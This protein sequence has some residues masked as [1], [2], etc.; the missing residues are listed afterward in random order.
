MTVLGL[1]HI[2]LVS[3][4]AQ[5]TV[6]FYTQVLGQRL[7]KQTVNF[8]D[9]GSYHLYFGDDG[10][11]PGRPGT[12]ITFFEWS[13]APKGYPGIGGTHHLALQVA[14]LDG[15]LKWKRRLIDLGLKVDGPYDRHYFT[16]I[17]FRDPDGV[18][19]EI[20]TQG[21]GWAVDEE[22]ERIGSEFRAPPAEMLVRNRDEERITAEMWPEPVPVITA[23]MALKHGLH[24][25]TAIG[26]NIQQLRRSE[27]G[28]LVLGCWRRQARH[29]DYLF[30]A[31][32]DEGTPRAHRNGADASL[33][34]GRAG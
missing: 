19:L 1:H 28:T 32:T 22:P 8:D 6:D 23:E 14:D 12:A 18:I 34:A 7:I 17:Y 27:L 16:S 4:N 20:A 31:P 21:P 33:C 25:I 11:K 13:H 29:V 15:L 24:H 5:R 9:P 2:T 10:V 30:R 26:S 3:A